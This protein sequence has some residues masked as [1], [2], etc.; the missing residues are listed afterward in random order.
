MNCV[1]FYKLKSSI[2][3][4]ALIDARNYFFRHKLAIYKMVAE[5]KVK[6][7]P[8][9]DSITDLSKV[10]ADNWHWFLD[11]SFLL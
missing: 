8:T 6:A 2:Q 7:S 4:Q 5:S 10:S 3:E 1:S 11:N 9:G